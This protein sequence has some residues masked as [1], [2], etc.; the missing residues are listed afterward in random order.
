MIRQF[1]NGSASLE[2]D[3]GSASLE[4]DKSLSFKANR[5]AFGLLKQKY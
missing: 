1:D 4:D 3:N 5:M 2:D